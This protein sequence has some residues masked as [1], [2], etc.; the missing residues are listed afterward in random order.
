MRVHTIL[1]LLTSGAVMTAA[2]LATAQDSEEIQSPFRPPVNFTDE[3]KAPPLPKEVTDDRRRTRNYP[4]QPPVIP[5]NIVGYQVTRNNN[6]CLTCHS[7]Q[8]TEQ[9][10]APMISI[11][12][13]QT[14]EGQ[15]LGAVAPRRYFCT[16]CHVPQTDA[17]PIVENRFKPFDALIEPSPGGGGGHP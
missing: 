7:R 1:A 3:P 4:E 9:T 12:H 15:T 5:H 6:Q 10:Q 16:Q 13:Y 11:S 8:F 14:R 2:A 17:K